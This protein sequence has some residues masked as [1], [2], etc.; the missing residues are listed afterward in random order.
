MQ[1]VGIARASLWRWHCNMLLYGRSRFES[2]NNIETGLD[3]S[4]YIYTDSTDLKNI[5]GITP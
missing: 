4:R 1:L 2:L 3:T 5:S